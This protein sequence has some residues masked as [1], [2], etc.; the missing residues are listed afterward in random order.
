MIKGKEAKEA[1][2]IAKE[3]RAELKSKIDAKLINNSKHYDLRRMA[4][5]T[6][7]LEDMVKFC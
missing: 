1:T 4:T 5:H 6:R 3:A 2:A 7:V